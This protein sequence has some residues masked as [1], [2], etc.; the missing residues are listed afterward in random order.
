MSALQPAS[1][2][3]AFRAAKEDWLIDAFAP[4]AAAIEH[5][6]NVLAE[7]QAAAVA[8]FGAAAPDFSETALVDEY[9][10]NPAKLKAFFQALGGRRS[11]EML[12]MVWRILQGMRI[13]RVHF[14]YA[15]GSFGLEVS[16][17][18]PHGDR[19]ETYTSTE[20][21]DFALLRQFGVARV[22]DKPVFDGFYPLRVR[23]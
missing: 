5:H 15:R 4:P 12:L 20:A 10:R 11:P 17:N 1:L 7:V 22:D 3:E 16:L 6:R 14:D 23:G 9:R 8:R 13:E 19:P 2:E 21:G 18:S